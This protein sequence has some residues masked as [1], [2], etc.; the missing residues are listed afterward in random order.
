MDRPEISAPTRIATAFGIS[1]LGLPITGLQ[2]ALALEVTRLSQELPGQKKLVPFLAASGAAAAIQISLD[3]A[4]AKRT[5]QFNNPV[6][7][8]YITKF[9]GKTFQAVLMGCLYGYVGMATNPIDLQMAGRALTTGDP[10]FLSCLLATHQMSGLVYSF[11]T[12]LLINLGLGET[13]AAKINPI[14]EKAKAIAKKPIDR[15]VSL[16]NSGPDYTQLSQQLEQNRAYLASI[17][18]QPLGPANQI[19]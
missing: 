4:T 15:F 19:Y 1:Q 11:G 17:A 5:G 7:Q 6:S 9:P 18:I 8:A 12:N 10:S 2:A 16:I 13:V 14:M 3:Y